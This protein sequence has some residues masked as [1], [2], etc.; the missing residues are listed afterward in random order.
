MR[1]ILFAGL[2]LV[3]I[4]FVF[5]SNLYSQEKKI[6]I[7]EIKE[8]I[9]PVTEKY[10]D[11][12][13]EVAEK[14]GY[15][16]VLFVLD[17]PGGLLESTRGIVQKLLSTGVDTI[18][19]VYPDGARAASAGVFITLAAKYAAMSKAC[20]IGAAHPVTLNQEGDRANENTKTLLKKMENDAVAFIESIAKKRNRNVKW[21]IDSVKNSV[22]ISAETALQLNVIDFVA[23]DIDE[24]LKKIYGKDVVFNKRWINKNWAEK[25][26]TILANPN[27]A[28]FLL[29]LG[30]YGIL[31]EIIHP[32][33][34]FSGVL[35]AICLILGLFSLQT[36]PVNF[37]GILLIILAFILFILE[38]YLTSY[39]MLT[40]GGIISL[41]L[42]SAMLFNSPYPFFRVSPVAI[43]VVVV[44]S[45]CFLGIILFALS[46]SIVR[47]PSSGREGMIGEE[48]VVFSNFVNKEG[49]VKVHG[50]IW[51]A[52][53]DEDLRINDIVKVDRING[54]KLWVSKV[55]R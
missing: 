32:G 18:V 54:L 33:T 27:L 36:L 55:K 41:V 26:L 13:I 7:G 38:V 34:I 11:R 6:I 10:V 53:S 21:A 42:G 3:I 12:L 29:I 31:Y 52:C 47:K 8:A 51:T 4:G 30:F 23:S 45:V 44:L 9:T 22:S 5:F 48:G 25:L 17:T 1:K 20:N 15:H 37:A 28:Y 35:G 50:E 43:G 39:G 46:K 49:L 14:E 40:I 2:S 19:F 24:L 16:A